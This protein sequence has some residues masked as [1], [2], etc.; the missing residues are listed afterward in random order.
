M[1]NNNNVRDR[2]AYNMKKIKKFN[3]IDQIH[4]T[5]DLK[6]II[7]KPEKIEK[8][9]IDIKA[10]A[11]NRLQANLVELKQSEQKRVNN[12]YKGIIKDFN[13]DKKLKKTEDLIIHKVTQNDKNMKSNVPSSIDGEKDE[14]IPTSV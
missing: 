11:N 1:N 10:L 13:Y 7:L 4:N 8:S 14:I 6:N 9:N 2:E 12:P 5:E 3:S